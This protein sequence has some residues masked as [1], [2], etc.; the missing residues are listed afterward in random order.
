[1]KAIADC[2]L[3]I[4]DL[5]VRYAL[6]CRSHTIGRAKDHYMTP[7]GDNDKLKHIGHSNRQS[8]MTQ[9]SD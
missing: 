8:A 3:P 4:A 6:A 2:Q 5:N 1:V 9:D 7:G